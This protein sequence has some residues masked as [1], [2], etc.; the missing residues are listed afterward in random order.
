[1]KDTLKKIC[2]IMTMVWAISMLAYADEL[3]IWTLSEPPGN[4]IDVNGEM[5]GL[6][7]DYIREIQKHVGYTDDIK[8]HIRFLPCT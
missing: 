5:T 2:F 8:S 7:V 1:M 6:T 4:F 3:K